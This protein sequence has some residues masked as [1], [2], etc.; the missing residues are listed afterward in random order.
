MASRKKKLNDFE[1]LLD[2]EPP[3]IEPYT[4]LELERSATADQIKSAYRKAALK[5]HPDKAPEDQKA[6]AHIKFQEVAFAYAILS[7]PRRRQR[8][9]TTGRTEESVDL[10]DDEFDWRDFFRAQMKEVVTNEAI[11]QFKSEYQGSEEEKSDLIAAYN[12]GKGDMDVI[13]EEVMLSNPVDDDARFREILNREIQDKTIKSYKKYASE[14]GASKKARERNAQKEAR[15]AEELAREM[16][17]HDKLFANGDAKKKTKKTKGSEPDESALAALIQS[18]N[19]QRQQDSNAFLDRLAEKYGAGS[20][21]G[22]KRRATEEPP[23]E[24][25]QETAKRGKRANPGKA[26]R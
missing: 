3:K 14:S 9:D 4:V 13:Y 22:A 15:E 1:E 2:E 8:Y 20:G 17:V 23:E 18:R 25:F 24:M 21:K 11:E 7:D 12:R 10:D 16:G 19:T 26:R 5:H 6:E